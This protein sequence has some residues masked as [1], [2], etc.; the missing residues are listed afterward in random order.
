[1]ATTEVHF[2]HPA[3]AAEEIY[4]RW[5]QFLDEEFTRHRSAEIRA[6]I[7][8]DQLYQLYLGR[9]H[10]GKLNLA[11]T[12][13]LPGNVI[14]LSLDPANAT[15]EAEHFPDIDAARFAP[16]KPLLWFW[17]MFDR[18]ALGLNHWLGIRLRCMLGRHIFAHLGKGVRIHRGVEFCYGYNLSIGD[19]VVIREGVLLNDCGG[20]NIGD[21]AVISSHA[22]IFS[23]AH[24]GED[25]EKL[26]LT[27]TAIGAGAR[28]GSHATVPAGQHVAAGETV[29]SFPAGSD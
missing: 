18:S 8:R 15:L 21:H 13:E 7:V 3:P 1:M 5:I 23:L 28:I 19:G 20:I 29:G 6:E 25:D 16:R 4:R 12:S 17:Q 27:P 14:G 11:L 26:R 9:P 24:A 2:P 22:R 10:G